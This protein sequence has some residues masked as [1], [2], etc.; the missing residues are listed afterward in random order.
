MIIVILPCLVYQDFTMKLWMKWIWENLCSFPSDSLKETTGQTVYRKS[1]TSIETA[2]PGNMI[3][4][5]AP[6]PREGG[7]L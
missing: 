4:E 3:I 6:S 2:I 5:L 7:Y 1:L